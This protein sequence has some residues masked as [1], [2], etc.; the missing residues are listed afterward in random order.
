M[1]NRA[2]VKQ[3]AADALSRL[4]TV[5]V[6]NT[7]LED[8]ISIMV[9]ARTKNHDQRNYFVPS[10]REKNKLLPKNPDDHNVELPT[11]SE[12]IIAQSKELFCE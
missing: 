5:G 2:Y 9:V 8:E 1:V 3:K 10:R 7:K 11:S 6:D 4:L 12:L